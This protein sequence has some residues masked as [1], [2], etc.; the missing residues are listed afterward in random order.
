MWA[1]LS[2]G[3]LLPSRQ[4]TNLVDHVGQQA[5]HLVP[6]NRLP[7]SEA[8]GSCKLC[9]GYSGPAQR[10]GSCCRGLALRGAGLWCVEAAVDKHLAQ[11][12][13]KG[14]VAAALERE[15]DASPYELLLALHK[16]EVK[17]LE[18]TAAD[19]GRERAQESPERG[20]RGEQVGRREGVG[21]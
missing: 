2:P 3:P 4:Q 19:G 21:C 18:V 13:A 15:V 6:I 8:D 11:E 16:R 20:K 7:A 10:G 17:P 14:H 12:I 5:L 1:V 9:N